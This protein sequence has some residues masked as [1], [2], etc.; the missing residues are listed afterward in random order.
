MNITKHQ[1]WK[2]SISIV[3]P[4]NGHPPHTH[5]YIRC[6]SLHTDWKSSISRHWLHLPRDSPFRYSPNNSY[7][8]ITTD[9]MTVTMA[10]RVISVL[11][12]AFGEFSMCAWRNAN[13]LC[14]C[15]VYACN[16][17]VICGTEG[18]LF[19]L[20]I[21]NLVLKIN[22]VCLR[23]VCWHLQFQYIFSPGSTIFSHCL[24]TR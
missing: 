9:Y 16:Y 15:D 21:L 18:L 3:R 20:P 10:S 24:K 2:K 11:F 1:T 13:T 17:V 4:S 6:I 5:T 14:K 8:S 19:E 7:Y 22:V 23:Y 12:Y